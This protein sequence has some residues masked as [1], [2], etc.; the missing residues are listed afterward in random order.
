MTLREAIRALECAGVPDAR[1][2]AREVFVRIGGLTRAQAMFPDAEAASPLVE[3]AI[4]RR[5]RREPLQYIIGEVGFYNE[6][7]EVSP[8]C[9]IPRSDTEALVEYA[10][11]H[12]PDGESFIDL[13]TGSGCIGISVLKNTR[14]ASA[15]LVDISPDALR[16]AQRNA[17]KNGVCDRAELLE[18][19]VLC[20]PVGA[21]V[22]CVLSNPPYVRPEVYETLERE[23]FYE[24]RAAFVAAD[25]GMEFYKRITELYRD[26]IKAGGFIAYEIGYDQEQAIREVARAADM[27]CETVRDLSGNPRVA[28]LRRR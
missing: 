2:D 14:A 23:I 3:D 9:L 16:T 25:G 15:L 5:V 20:E 6:V 26:R 4:A 13:C 24:P 10:V 21:E 22:F 11:A 27:S 8:D 18:A 28:V 1:Y 19:D 12:I 7:Y 17:Q